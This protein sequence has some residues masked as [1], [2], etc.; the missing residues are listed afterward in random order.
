MTHPHGLVENKNGRRSAEAGHR[1]N[2][3][4]FR[5]IGGLLHRIEFHEKIPQNA[6]GGKH[7]PGQIQGRHPFLRRKFRKIGNGC[8]SANGQQE[9]NNAHIFL[10]FQKWTRPRLFPHGTHPRSQAYQNTAGMTMKVLGSRLLRCC[11]LRLFLF[12]IMIEY[13]QLGTRQTRCSVFYQN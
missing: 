8:N 9:I 13:P 12:E 4:Q 2:S 5:C 3:E 11:S 10:F 1:G 6:C 7:D